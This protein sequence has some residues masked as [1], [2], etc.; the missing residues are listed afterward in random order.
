M[1]NLNERLT[2]MEEKI[3]DQKMLEVKEI[4]ESQAIIDEIVV[5]NT[6]DIVLMKKMKQDNNDSIMTLEL[7]I[8]LLEKEI[9]KRNKV[10]ENNYDKQNEEVKEMQKKLILCRY[11]N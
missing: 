3:D 11:H 7:K 9:Q 4:L 8:N 2:S 5:K 6:D 10:L 1:T